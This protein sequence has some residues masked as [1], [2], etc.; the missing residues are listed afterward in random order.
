M[1]TVQKP[2]NSCFSGGAHHLDVQARHDK[3]AQ[4]MKSMLIVFNILGIAQCQSIL[5]SIR[6]YC[7]PALLY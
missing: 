5:E 1:G 2:H 6:M 3:L 7:K 4:N